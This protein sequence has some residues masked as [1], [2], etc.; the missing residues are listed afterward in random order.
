[1]RRVRHTSGLSFYEE[2]SSANLDIIR[3]IVT[4]VLITAGAIGLGVA[5]T[6]YLGFRC[7]VSGDAMTPILADGQQVLVNKVSYRVTSPKAGDVIAY[8]PGGNEDT[9]P[10]VSRIVAVGKQTVQILDGRLLVN[11]TPYS[12]D[13]IY[14]DITYA[15]IAEQIVTLDE[16]EVFLLGDNT[17]ASEDSRSAGIG[18]VRES[19][20]IGQVWFALPGGGGSMGTV[21]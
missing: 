2:T 19:D 9:Y 20:I 12:D 16:D 13:P 15:G 7:A 6:L 14:S 5:F 18:A 11:G 21:D 1:M 3:R 10:M 8:Y 17:A 4:W